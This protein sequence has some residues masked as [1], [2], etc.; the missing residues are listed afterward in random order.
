MKKTAIV[1]SAVLMVLAILVC[2]TYA[3]GF[4]EVATGPCRC[5]PFQVQLNHT[6]NLTWTLVNSYNTTLSFYI[7]PAGLQ[8]SNGIIP[9]ISYKPINGTIPANDSEYS[10]QVS[11]AMPLGAP[12][13]QSWSGIM[14]AFATS[15]QQSVGG[16]AIQIG[17]AKYIDIT[18]E[19]STTTTTTSLSTTSTIQQGININLEGNYTPIYIVGVIIVIIIAYMAGRYKPKK[20]KVK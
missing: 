12:V 1:G 9:I 2:T 5:L 20:K 6:E 15:T 3:S 17:T 19:A 16:S 7:Q 10:I 4:G 13:N 14:T 8:P 18:S 11:V